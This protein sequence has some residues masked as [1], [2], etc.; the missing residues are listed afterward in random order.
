MVNGVRSQRFDTVFVLIIFSVFAV[1]V[2]IV[3][4]LGA[5]IYRNISDVSSEG[6]DERSVLAYI[7]TKSKNFNEAGMIS[8][9]SFHGENALV[10]TEEFS[11]IEYQTVVYYFDGW[12]CELF[13]EKGLGLSPADGVRVMR[14]DSLSFETIDYGLIRV[15]AGDGSLLISPLGR[16]DG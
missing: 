10:I 13:T 7:W 16:F 11:G 6:A 3:L 1:S 12:L 8:L 9:T 15:T 4:M 14:L 5:S 2:L